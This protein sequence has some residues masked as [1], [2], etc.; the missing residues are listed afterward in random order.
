MKALLGII[1]IALCAS[2]YMCT[3]ETDTAPGSEY[4]DYIE[5]HLTQEGFI[6][7]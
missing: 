7:I 5:V 2:I 4:N 3:A 1:V 6:Y